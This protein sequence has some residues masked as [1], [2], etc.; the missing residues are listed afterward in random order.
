MSCRLPHEAN[1][2]ADSSTSSRILLVTGVPGIGKTTLVRRLA[3]QLQQ[4]RIGG[5]YTEEI[6][7]GGQRQGFRLVTKWTMAGP[8]TPVL[9]ARRT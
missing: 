1:A 9:P 4:Y 8:S 5:F 6:R 7:T 2:T 3:M